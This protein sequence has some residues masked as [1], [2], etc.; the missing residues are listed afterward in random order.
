MTP[1]YPYP[2]ST[3]LLP[4]DIFIAAA[5]VRSHTKKTIA[6]ALFRLFLAWLTVIAILRHLRLY[7]LCSFC[8][9]VNRSKPHSS[10]Q[11]CQSQGIALSHH[12]WSSFL[13]ALLER[14]GSSPNSLAGAYVLVPACMVPESAVMTPSGCRIT[15][16]DNFAQAGNYSTWMPLYSYASMRG[17]LMDHGLMQPN[18]TCD[19]AAD[20]YDIIVCPPFTKKAPQSA[21]PAHCRE[22]GVTSCPNVTSH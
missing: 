17:L 12:P 8:K 10:V 4:A 6:E 18:G 20:L 9:S 11:L 1:G 5:T 19:P 3:R 15:K 13:W 14:P 7:Q 2:V 16:D 21:M 22:Q